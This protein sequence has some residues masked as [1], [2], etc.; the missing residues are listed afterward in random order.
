MLSRKCD[1]TATRLPSNRVRLFLRHFMRRPFDARES[2]YRRIAVASRRVASQNHGITVTSPSRA[3]P[4]M[5]IL[6]IK[7]RAYCT[8]VA[9]WPNGRREGTCYQ[10]V[11]GSNPDRLAA[12]CNPGQVVHID[13]PLSPSSIIWYQP[14]GSDARWLGR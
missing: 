8:G 7:F 3:T 6:Y 4:G 2:C 13:V 10:Q 11:A 1:A 9:R 14:I 5:R 12:E